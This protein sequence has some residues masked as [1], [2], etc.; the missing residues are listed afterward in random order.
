MLVGAEFSLHHFL[1][2]K[3]DYVTLLYLHL[4]TI[5]HRCGKFIQIFM[6]SLASCIST[7]VPA[8]ISLTVPPPQ[9]ARYWVTKKS[10]LCLILVGAELSFPFFYQTKLSHY[11][12]LS[13]SI[14]DSPFL[15]QTYMNFEELACLPFSHLE[16]Y[17]YI[18][19]LLMYSK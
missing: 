13:P 10:H 9:D 15:Q 19:S 16:N 7:I 2:N 18:L 6:N 8:F 1:S 3:N 17:H 12:F 5:L 14:N 4:I 11:P